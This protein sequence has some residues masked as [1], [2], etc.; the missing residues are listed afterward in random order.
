MSLV[1][2]ADSNYNR[3]ICINISVVIDSVVENRE[4]FFTF[5]N[6][7]DTSVQNN[8]QPKSLIIIQDNTGQYL[9]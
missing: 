2:V 4:T 3:S 7:S 8:I 1:F 5:I 6:T 9:L